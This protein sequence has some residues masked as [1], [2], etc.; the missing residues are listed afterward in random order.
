M[1]GKLTLKDQLHPI[2]IMIVVGWVLVICASKRLN[3]KPHIKICKPKNNFAK[4][5]I[6][7]LKNLLN[8]SSSC[9]FAAD[10]SSLVTC[11]ETVLC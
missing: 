7:I 4:V 2:N 1:K 9:A 3:I 5:R 8:I 6:L 11:H 10:L